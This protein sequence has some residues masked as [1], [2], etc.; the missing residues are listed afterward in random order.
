MAG[1]SQYSSDDRMSVYLALVSNDGNVKRTARDTGFSETT[2]RRWKKEFDA[3]PPDRE[4]VVEAVE[5]GAYVDKL[6]STR[7][8]A[9]THL[10]KKIPEASAR[11][12]GTIYGILEDKLARID[13]IGNDNE[14]HHFHHLPPAEEVAQLLT[15]LGQGAISDTR[16]RQTELAETKLR[17]QP[18][19][20]PG[21]PSS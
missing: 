8:E 18:A 3:N 20:M 13:K 9:L 10:R 21:L 12:L 7:D 14:H 16:Q 6:R 1:K 2:V 17:E 15:G 4:A 11:D 5:S 19:L